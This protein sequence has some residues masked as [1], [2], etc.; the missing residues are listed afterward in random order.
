MSTNN[1]QWCKYKELEP[2]PTKI[3][4]VP[5]KCNLIHEHPMATCCALLPT[6]V[7]MKA[8]FFG[9]FILTI[10]MVGLQLLRNTQKKEE[11]FKEI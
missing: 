9:L 5:S 11:F 4:Q 8:C 2:S 3:Y 10:L 7:E 1:L 6:E